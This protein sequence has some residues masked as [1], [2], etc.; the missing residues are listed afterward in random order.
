MGSERS[1]DELVAF[2]AQRDDADASV[3]K[4][5]RSVV[6]RG[7]PGRGAIVLLH[8]LTAGPP[9]WRAVARTLASR[10]HTVVVPRLFL[11]GHRD[12]MTRV[13]RHL[14]ADT[15]IDD[16]AE[17]VTRVAA[18]GEAV[19][20]A[21]YSL[22]ATL[23]I[24]AALRPPPVARIVAVAPFLG[25]A[26]IPLE[27][28]APLRGVLAR[29][30]NVFLWWDPVARERQRPDHGY[31]RYPLQSIVVGLSIADRAR[32]S[33]R[34]PPLAGSIHLVLNAR[35]SSVNNR[36]AERLA[37]DWRAAGASVTLH[38]LRSLGWS[39]DIVEPDRRWSGPALEPL[40]E[41][42]GGTT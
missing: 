15:L 41:V 2:L 39:H 5:M 29:F 21:G 24:D 33:A 30:P 20:V 9:A 11:H 7:A 32:H 35:E 6:Y 12:R 38:V 42:I 16:T 14:R 22:G 10:G 18:L 13:L 28:H 36:T 23:A 1:L 34:R 3:A 17:V 27:L 37:R 40:I 25:I 8:G 26:N 4:E 31:P 19:T